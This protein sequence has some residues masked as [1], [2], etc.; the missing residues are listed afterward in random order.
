MLLDVTAQRDQ[1]QRI[2]QKA[3]E[4]TLLQEQEALL[5]RSLEAANAALRATQRELHQ[6]T[7]EPRAQSR[8]CG[9][10]ARSP[11]Q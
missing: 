2:Q 7:D 4:M 1:T 6:R 9:R 10:S 11:R 5:N 3:Y 8:S